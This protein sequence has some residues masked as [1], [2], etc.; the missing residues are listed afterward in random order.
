MAGF[1]GGMAGMMGGGGGGGGAS[2]AGSA[3]QAGAAMIPKGDP[4]MELMQQG[5]SQPFLGPGGIQGGQTAPPPLMGAP[6]GAQMMPP[7]GQ[8][9]PPTML[10]GMAPTGVGTGAEAGQTAGQSAQLANLMTQ[11]Q[12]QRENPMGGGGA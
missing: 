5:G 9:P 3:L 8:E 10:G 2:L 1:L 11:I 7:M 12:M 4:G 6:G